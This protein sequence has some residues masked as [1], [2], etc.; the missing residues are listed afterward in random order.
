MD[1][2]QQKRSREIRDLILGLNQQEQGLFERFEQT[3]ERGSYCCEDCEI[4]RAL[5]SI[6]DD[7]EGLQRELAAIDQEQVVE[8]RAKLENLE[9]DRLGV[10]SAGYPKHEYDMRMST[11]RNKREK[12]EGHVQALGLPVGA[13]RVVLV[14]FRREFEPAVREAAGF[15]HF[16]RLPEPAFA[17]VEDRSPGAC[18]LLHRSNQEVVEYV[19]DRQ[20]D[21][22]RP[23]DKPVLFFTGEVDTVRGYCGMTVVPRDLVRVV[24]LPILL[25]QGWDA[26]MEAVEKCR[27]AGYE[28]GQETKMA[29]LLGLGDVT[30]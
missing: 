1:T 30:P 18:Y 7:R 14:D 20:D 22:D 24:L 4:G 2:N 29:Q 27:L 19:L 10:V 12:V 6:R 25:G 23:W 3:K 15:Q 26:M 13:A 11:I 21:A 17:V 8:L 9:Q 16:A 28:Y 5:E